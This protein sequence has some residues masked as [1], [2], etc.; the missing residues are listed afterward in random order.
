MYNC[1]M[2]EIDETIHNLPIYAV[3][4]CAAAVGVCTVGAGAIWVARLES[5]PSAKR[6]PYFHPLVRCLW[7]T[8]NRH[9]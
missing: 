9:G 3:Y 4:V 7:Y 5:V 6:V 2:Y 1:P 8:I